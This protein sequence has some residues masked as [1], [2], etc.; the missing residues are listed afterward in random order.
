MCE[1]CWSQVPVGRMNTW[2][3]ASESYNQGEEWRPRRETLQHYFW[4]SMIL[5]QNTA[6]DLTSLGTFPYLGWSISYNNSNWTAV[7]Q[8]LQ[9]AQR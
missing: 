9:K 4:E 1:H 6:E 3:Y 7:Y 5:F 8:N 2:Y